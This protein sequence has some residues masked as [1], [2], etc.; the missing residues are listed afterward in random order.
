MH[1][2]KLFV[3]AV[4]F[5]GTLAG[6]ITLIV[7]GT[8]S[9]VASQPTPIPENVITAT[10]RP[11]TLRPS[12]HLVPT[13]Q[14]T[15]PPSTPT[16]RQ[17][18]S[19]SPTSLAPTTHLP[20][21]QPSLAPIVLSSAVTDDAAAGIAGP[22]VGALFAFAGIAGL[23]MFANTQKGRELRKKWYG[24]PKLNEDE[25]SFYQVTNRSTGESQVVKGAEDLTRVM[26]R[27]Q[28]NHYFTTGLA[29]PGWEIQLE[30]SSTN[31]FVFQ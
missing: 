1:Y 18:T 2:I 22:V 8:R 11:S 12:T 3:L 24:G 26:G 4:L 23:A 25:H 28:T 29:P 27:E 14:P 9:S 19:L 31:Q 30:H 20:S 16:T 13:H 15:R 7:L 5:A 17:P 6:T 21:S 10:H